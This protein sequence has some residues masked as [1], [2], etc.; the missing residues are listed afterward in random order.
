M[1]I[2]ETLEQGLFMLTRYGEEIRSGKT[3][4]EAVTV[5]FSRAGRVIFVSG[6]TP[7]GPIYLAVSFIPLAAHFHSIYV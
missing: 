5:A 4:L 1:C 6:I 2:L 7:T 3:N